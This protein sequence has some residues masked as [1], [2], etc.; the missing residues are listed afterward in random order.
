MSL[1]LSTTSHPLSEFSTFA[2]MLGFE[3]VCGL[4]RGDDGLEALFTTLGEFL[5]DSCDTL[6]VLEFTFG[7]PTTGSDERRLF[8]PRDL[9]LDLRP[10]GPTKHDKPST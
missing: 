3:S 7:L 8:R 9:P 2:R 4:A 10:F 1:S 5:D 6:V